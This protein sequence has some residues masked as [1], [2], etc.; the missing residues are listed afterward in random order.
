MNNKM[1]IVVALFLLSAIAYSKPKTKESRSS[2]NQKYT[3]KIR[4]KAGGTYGH[5]IKKQKKCFLLFG[6]SFCKTIKIQN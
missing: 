1:L 5:K 4:K 3:L 2:H 6:M